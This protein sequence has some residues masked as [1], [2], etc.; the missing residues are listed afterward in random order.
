MTSSELG[1]K[2]KNSKQS[3]FSISLSVRWFKNKSRLRLIIPYSSKL[4]NTGGALVN[5]FAVV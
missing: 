4:R 3:L 2:L 5:A 1:T